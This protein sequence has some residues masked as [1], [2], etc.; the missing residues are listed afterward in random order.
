[1]GIELSTVRL[2]RPEPGDIERMYGYRNDTEVAHLLGGFSAGFS[3]KDFEE[4]IER[5]RGRSDEV[6]W[7]IADATSDECIGHVGLYEIDHRV[8]KAEFAICIGDKARWGKGLGVEVGKAVLR[9]AFRE[10]NLN[11][12]SL[13]VLDSNKGAIKLYEKLAF[14]L[15][16]RL[17]ADQFRD[18]KYV[19]S[20]VMSILAEEWE[21]SHGAG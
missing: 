4:W 7:I 3:R 18:G 19:D 8:R 20:L 5:H 10:L 9:F 17:R 6:I 11:K 16:G 14:K 1:M 13:E 21:S 12:V 15:D 2:R